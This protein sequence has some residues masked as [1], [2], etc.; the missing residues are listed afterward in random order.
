MESYSASK[1]LSWCA[2]VD[3]AFS[4]AEA[5]CEVWGLAV[6]SSLQQG[7]RATVER[8]W[9]CWSTRTEEPWWWWSTSPV[10]E[11]EKFCLEK[12]L[13]G[14]SSVSVNAWIRV[15][16]PRSPVRDTYCQENAMGTNKTTGDS[17]WPSR[18]TSEEKWEKLSRLSKRVIIFLDKDLQQLSG[19]GSMQPSLGDPPW[20]WILYQMAFKSPFLKSENK[21]LQL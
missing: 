12:A 1:N 13:W 17:L 21:T 4:A 3:T 6:G 2:L 14:I 10:R 16:D 19:H 11:L 9:R 18:S 20:A 8:P 5:T 7:H 15:K